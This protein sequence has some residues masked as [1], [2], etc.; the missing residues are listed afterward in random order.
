MRAQAPSL[1]PIFRSDLQAR[2]LAALLDGRRASWTVSELAAELGRPLPSVNREV[3]RLSEAGILSSERRGGA[4][5]VTANAEWPYLAELRRLVVGTAGVPAVLRA[6]LADVPGIAA[7]AIFGSWAARYLGT[8]G[9]A[10]ADIDLLVVGDPDPEAVHAACAA[11]EAELGRPVNPV[12]V[13]PGAWAARDSAFLRNVAG[14]ALVPVTGT[15]P[16]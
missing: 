12:F 3:L 16:A 13:S 6:A 2:L 14:G 7:A 15:L 4:R 8:P 11:C 5:F 10:P 9:D 1:V